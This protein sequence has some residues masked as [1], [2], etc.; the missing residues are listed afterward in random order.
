MRFHSAVHEDRRERRPV[1]HVRAG[2]RAQVSDDRGRGRDG[3][4]AGQHVRFHV[5][6]AQDHLLH[7]SRRSAVQ[8]SVRVEI[9]KELPSNIAIVVTLNTPSFA[10]Y[11]FDFNTARRVAYDLCPPVPPPPRAPLS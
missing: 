9:G 6:D 2:G 10:V 11:E 7:G 4:S 1:G 3:R 8:V 5:P